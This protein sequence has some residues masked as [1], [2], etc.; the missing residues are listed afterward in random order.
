MIYLLDT[1]LPGQW[2]T[3]TDAQLAEELNEPATMRPMT[4]EKFFGSVV[5]QGGDPATL[6][7]LWDVGA[8]RLVDRAEASLLAGDLAGVLAYIATIPPGSQAAIGET[9]MTAMQAVIGAAA[10]STWQAKVAGPNADPATAEAVTA[11]MGGQGWTWDGAAWGYVEPD[12]GD[13][14]IG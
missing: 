12:N 6:G 2:A 8:G 1:I 14:A 7:E 5:A 4:M 13:L 3:M 10:L 9:T 11:W